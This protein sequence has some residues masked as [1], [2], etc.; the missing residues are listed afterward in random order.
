M[1]RKILLLVFVLLTLLWIV[2]I[3]ANSLDNAAE[4]TKKSSFVTELV[5]NIAS[6]IGIKREIPHSTV[7]TIAHFSE[8]LILSLLICADLLIAFLPLFLNSRLRFIS[9]ALLSVGASFVVACFDEFLQNF[10]DGRAAQLSDI[11][12]DTAGAFAGAVFFTAIFLIIT[13]IFK[14]SLYRQDKL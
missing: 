8:F 6:F 2:F 12:T 9:A 4:S 3:H 11:F 5:N 14:K 13:Q 10:S 1:K 7:R